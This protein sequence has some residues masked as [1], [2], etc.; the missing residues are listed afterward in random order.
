MI[1]G[2]IFVIGFVLFLLISFVIPLPPGATIVEEFIPDVIGTAY[3]GAVA[4]IINGVIYGVIIWIIFSV[5]KI[6][7][8][9]MKGPKEVVVKVETKDAK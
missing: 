3:E 2:I 6:V 8:D 5:V 1:G 9:K 4:G 7:Y